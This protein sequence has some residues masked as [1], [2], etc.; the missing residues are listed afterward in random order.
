VLYYNFAPPGTLAGNTIAD[1]SGN[2]RPA[3]IVTVGAG[4][5]GYNPSTPPALSLYSS[6]SLRLTQT[7]SG[8]A[9]VALTR[10]VT[11]GNLSMTNGSWTFATW[12]QRA[13]ITND[14][15]LFYVGSSKGFGGSGD[16]LQLY[17]PG[18]TNSV[19]LRHYNSNNQIDVD[20][21]SSTVVGTGQ[22][23]H[24]ALV[25]QHIADN[26]NTVSLY[27]DGTIVGAVS[28][29]AWAL[30]Q[31]YPLVFGGHNSTTSRVYRWL[32]GSLDD[33][34]LFRGA[35]TPAE[36]AQLATR[37]ISHFGGFTVTN[38]VAISVVAPP[39]T[40]PTLVAISNRTINAGVTLVVT[41]IATDADQPPQT[42][43]FGLAAAPTNA[44]ITTDTGILL[45][46]PTLAQANAAYPFSV[47][48]TDN[49]TPSLSATQSFV[50]TVNPLHAPVLAGPTL[51]NNQIAFQVNGDSGPDYTIE[52][53]TNLAAWTALF[54]TNS[55]ALP[56]S[57]TDTNSTALPQRF[58]RLRLGP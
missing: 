51:A 47:T 54:T 55:P 56:F 4:A 24:V 46:R 44:S 16:E 49:G 9:A 32:N 10:T 7:N 41:N 42:L 13:A 30:R 50:V 22:W 15:F 29:V 2:A 36:I 33:L 25:F 3:S 6:Q 27:L 57:W 18:N 45:W 17:C 20:I 39:N 37:T 23:H 1:I 14:H 12:F 40:A 48:V 58:Y 34:A 8:A 35:L 19:E 28:N 11:P 38:V 52:A 43:T 26:T 31:D 53:S 21:P 5:P